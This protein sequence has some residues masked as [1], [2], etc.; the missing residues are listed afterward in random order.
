[1]TVNNN[2]PTYT[3]Q[4][5]EQI[6]YVNYCG[7][8]EIFL[9]NYLYQPE[10][11]KMRNFTLILIL[12]LLPFSTGS[13]QCQEYA[14]SS[15][16][17]EGNWLKIKTTREGITRIDYS[18][19]SSLS[20]NGSEPVL[21]GNNNGLLSYYNDGTSPDDLVWISIYTEKG[22][23]GIFNS[24]DYI[25]FY[26][27]SPNRWYISEDGDIDYKR[28]NYADTAV[29]FITSGTNPVYI[30]SE[31]SA[32]TANNNSSYR[33]YLFIH[34][35]DE[36]NILKS[37]R[38]WYQPVSTLQPVNIANGLSQYTQEPGE[39]PQFAIRVLARSAIPTLF[40]LNLGTSLVES[41]G[42]AEVNLLNS[43]GTYARLEELSGS[44]S[45]PGATEQMTVSYH[46]NGDNS[47]RGWLDYVRI[48]ARVRSSYQNRQ[49]VVTD[50]KSA[51][52]GI[53][54]RFSIQSSATSLMVWD[55][56]DCSSPVNI[57]TTVLPGELS[58]TTATDSVRKFIV[59]RLEDTF[60]PLIEGPVRNQDLHSGSGYDMI[61]VTH[62]RFR[63]WA[64][65]LAAIHT[66]LNS[67]NCI[68][69]TP[70]EIYNEFS[71][72][73][74]DITAIR[75]YVRMIW[76]RGN[77]TRPLKNLLLFGD[78]SFENRRPPPQN[79]N[80]IP[81]YQT[82]NSN[83]NILSFTSDDYY[84]LLDPGEGETS[85]YIDIGIGR[86][87]VTTEAE[88]AVMINKIRRYTSAEA[89]GPW[90]N[91]ITMVADDEDNNLHLS[92]AEALS[93]LVG[94][95]APEYNIEKIYFDSYPQETS[96]TGDSYPAATE[97][98]NNR[99]NDGCLIFN[100]LGHGNELGLAHERVVKIEDINS[101]RNINRMP[102]FIT[103][104]CE[105]SRFD[106]IE[107]DPASGEISLK[108]SAGEMVLMNPDGGAIALLTTTRIVYSAPNYTLNNRI[109]QYAF[110]RDDNGEG[111]TLGE[112]M[113]LAKNNA[114]SGDNKRNF[115]LLGDPALKLSYPWH[116][117]VVTDSINGVHTSSFTD[118]L[119]ALSTVT[120]SGHIENNSGAIYDSFNGM[121]NIS[122]FDKEYTVSTLANDGGVA[123]EY[124]LQDRLLFKGK[125][126]VRD[127]LFKSTFMIPRDIDYNYGMGR[128]SLYAFKEDED[129]NGR[130]SEVKVGGFNNIAISDTTGPKIR[131]F[132]N[133]TLF[134]NGGITDGT[135]S[136][137]AFINDPGG[138]NTTGTG[139]GHD[140]IFYLDDDRNR[141]VVL[142]NYFE[143]DPGSYTSGSLT[144][145][146]QALERGTHIL[147][148]KA[149]DNFNNSNT[150]DLVFIVEPEGK[151]I[152]NRLINWPN[153]FAE[154]T[155][156]N[157]E[158]NRPDQELSITINIF[159]SNGRLI[160]KINSNQ[161]VS[162]YTLQPV[163]WNG[164]DE[165]GNRVARGLYIYTVTIVTEENEISTL[166][167][168]M[169]IL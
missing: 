84:G 125:A 136:L 43:A 127:G 16:L 12:L 143:N 82:Q 147:H 71:G 140:I 60:D 123:M 109:Y 157:L 76:E 63:Q 21:Y 52:E 26:A 134:R 97:A 114:G 53:I 31:P 149:W 155:K 45:W 137:L 85:G 2:N 14:S 145:G 159:S 96:I 13:T 1:M 112:I 91:I 23:D 117:T 80:Y 67:Y 105:F 124:N 22:S 4:Q 11:S 150:S 6:L 89:M 120:F 153:P 98:I 116:G 87:P 3:I 130:Y 79:P 121:V 103:A 30:A 141:S 142:N 50:Y 158:H 164:F 55:V 165:G 33:D 46:N 69:V 156:I 93:E 66:E 68:V 108:P 7:C 40:R 75:N 18:D 128:M 131:L 29:Y 94:S 92:D 8:R 49:L 38:E 129:F 36:Q 133:D 132:L 126:E 168:R 48:H 146:L 81:T 118:T 73:I 106:D 59:F 74:T 39:S 110:S 83:V 138:I 9:L 163:E 64:D 161:R 57:P 166:S 90:R 119:N 169:V 111:L 104:T 37:G 101:W 86:L 107:S 56:T 35:S 44:F 139:I 151:F 72:G 17:K 122:F 115:T 5:Y 20:F 65:E 152:L 154:S 19:I 113:R 144:F 15:A 24:G 54:T 70:G 10:Y 47:S 61:I 102:V 41:I 25:L 148:L 42:I 28:H 62:P 167:G 51:G 58:F 78:G 135:P 88:A 27:A 34:E 95:I 77:G 100:Y 32:V 162:G 160:K 99:I